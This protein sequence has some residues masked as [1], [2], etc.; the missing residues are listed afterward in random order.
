M[1]AQVLDLTSDDEDEDAPLSSR[2][3]LAPRST[4]AARPPLVFRQFEGPIEI[5]LTGEGDVCCMVRC[6]GAWRC[7]WA[8]L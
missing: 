4:A 2:Q 7:S 8:G 3:P 1:Q 6:S 5:D